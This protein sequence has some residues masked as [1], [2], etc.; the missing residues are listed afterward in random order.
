MSRNFGI[1]RHS[2]VP[3]P[4]LIG[5]EGWKWL[6]TAGASV[7]LVAFMVTIVV[8]EI[9]FPNGWADLKDTIADTHVLAVAGDRVV[10]VLF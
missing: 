3:R 10:A 8:L 2:S 9:E 4:Q 7:L 6:K 1:P 5:E